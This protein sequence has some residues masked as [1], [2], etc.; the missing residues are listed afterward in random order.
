MSRI[1]Y[2]RYGRMKYHP[3]FHQRQGQ[4]WTTIDVRF[5]V[6]NYY[7]IGPEEASFALSRTIHSVM[8]MVYELRKKGVMKPPEGREYKK[9]EV[10]SRLT[11]S[12]LT[13]S[14]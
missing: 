5:L 2:D 1:E 8:Q 4:P 11:S 3:D 13:V 7:K 10:A 14:K 12:D 9:R 6:D